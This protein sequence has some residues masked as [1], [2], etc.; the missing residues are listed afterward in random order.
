MDRL[1]RINLIYANIDLAKKDT[2][3]SECVQ[4]SIANQQIFWEKDELLVPDVCY[5]SPANIYISQERSIEAAA[6]YAGKR[7]CVLNFASFVTPGGGVLRGTTAQEESICRVT[8]LY[9]AISDE[10]VSPFY[11]THKNQIA[12]GKVGRK[13]TDDCIYSPNILCFREDTFDCA[14]LPEDKW[15]E[16]SVITCA[17]PDQRY[18]GGEREYHPNDVEQL[19]D[20]E[21]RIH[22]ILTIAAM[23][24]TE[25]LI[26]GA[27]GCG[28][29]GNSPSV[30][31]KAFENQMSQFMHHFE[32]IEFAIYCSNKHDDNYRAFLSIDT[33]KEIPKHTDEVS[34]TVHPA[35]VALP[36]KWKNISAKEVERTL[37]YLQKYCYHT[38]RDCQQRM[39]FLIKRSEESFSGG[40][41]GIC[42][43]KEYKRNLMYIKP[44]TSHLRY[45]KVAAALCF[46]RMQAIN[47]ET[48][49]DD[50]I[51]KIRIYSDAWYSH[52]TIADG[53][54]LWRVHSGFD[55]MLE[56][57]Q[58]A[59]CES[60]GNHEIGVVLDVFSALQWNSNRIRE[61][62]GYLD[63][64]DL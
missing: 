40:C 11:T 30:V 25:V 21:K 23:Y 5:A 3:I 10:S 47:S 26:L 59:Y 48:S 33:I 63:N 49:L 2:K 8:S 9:S 51:E 37:Q 6:K 54:F 36:E 16:I 57:L 43:Y 18:C 7:V 41:G 56:R 24:K 32:T 17:A 53:E 35:A 45:G 29:F 31:A 28:V 61:I 34:L 13:N 46:I 15:Y 20:F 38:D 64:D 39:D 19:H 14:M 60:G 42:G 27:F 12:E 55:A 52:K 4:K 50:V 1:E 62:Q 44:Y 22:R 58:R